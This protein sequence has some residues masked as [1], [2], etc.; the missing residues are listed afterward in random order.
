MMMKRW[1]AGAKL[2]KHLLSSVPIWVRLPGLPLEYSTKER[3]NIIASV[4][5]NPI[6]LIGGLKEFGKFR[7]L[8]FLLKSPARL[9][10]LARFQF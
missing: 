2:N 9:H 1:S 8:E 3:I 7:L 10:F 4:I 6:N 5:G